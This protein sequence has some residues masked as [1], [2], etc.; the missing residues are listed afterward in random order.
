LGGREYYSFEIINTSKKEFMQYYLT[1]FLIYLPT[2]NP[3]GELSNFP[4]GK[5][6]SYPVGHLSNFPVWKLIYLPTEN[7]RAHLLNFP[8]WKL[9]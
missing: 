5:F 8:V 6:L 1:Q 4:V 2:D 7:F 9:L 3:V